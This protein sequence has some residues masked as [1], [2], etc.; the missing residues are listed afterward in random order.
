M[1]I[2]ISDMTEETKKIR[3]NKA[4]K[5]L[6]VGISTLVEF[7]Q[8]KGHEVEQNPNTRITMEQ[9]ELLSKAFH[10]EREVKENADKIEITPSNSAVVIE[11]T[12]TVPEDDPIRYDNEELTIKN[13]SSTPKRKEEP[14]PAPAD[15]KEPQ[16]PAAETPATSEPVEVEANVETPAPEPKQEP[17]E[18]KFETKV[19]KTTVAGAKEGNDAFSAELKIVNKIDLDSLNTKV[20]PDKKSRNEK[21][22]ENRRK[23]KENKNKAEKSDTN[24]STPNDNKNR[25]ENK[26]SDNSEKRKA[27]NPNKGTGNKNVNPAQPAPNPPA[28]NTTVEQAPKQAPKEVEFIETQYQKLEGPKVVSKIDL[29]QF[30]KPKAKSHDE[31]KNWNMPKF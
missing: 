7:L 4:A 20:R 23:K 14:A 17:Q 13:Y 3:L 21:A 2:Q 11:A 27:D 30:E 1:D 28:E 8:K 24:N 31:K 15:K 25:N 22:E 19:I 16:E 9:Y 12:T 29:T 5:D 6:N 26:K 18:P 10:A